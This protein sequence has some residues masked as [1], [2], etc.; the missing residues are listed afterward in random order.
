[1]YVLTQ[2][3]GYPV[4]GGMGM[5]FMDGSYSSAILS[6]I[7][8]SLIFQL[9]SCYLFQGCK[10]RY[11]FFSTVPYSTYTTTSRIAKT[12]PV[13]MIQHKVKKE[14]AVTRPFSPMLCE[15]FGAKTGGFRFLAEKVGHKTVIMADGRFTQSPMPTQQF[16]RKLVELNTPGN[17]N[18]SN[19]CRCT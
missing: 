3:A 9:H 11:V 19:Y 1:M 6:S 15:A 12:E 17:L 14:G 10:R 5:C 7:L 16:L 2:G 18:L 8:C 13:T 4:R